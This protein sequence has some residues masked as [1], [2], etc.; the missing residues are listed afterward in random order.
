MEDKQRKEEE[1][2]EEDR[3]RAEKHNKLKERVVNSNFLV[4][5]TNALEEKRKQGQEQ[6]KQG[7]RNDK[8][9]YEEKLQIGLQKIYNRPLMFESCILLYFKHNLIATK[10]MDKMN[11][12]MDMKDKLG[13]LL[14]PED[15][16]EEE[17][18]AEENAKKGSAE[19]A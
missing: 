18:H 3:L 19:S 6:F 14:D 5:N 4:D 2:I 10:K 12:M 8:Q 1:K 7:L 9:K 17:M 13:N 11:N 15:K 16:T